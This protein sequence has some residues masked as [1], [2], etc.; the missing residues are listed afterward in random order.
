MARCLGAAR[1]VSQITTED[2]R[3]RI[4]ENEVIRVCHFLQPLK[5]T[6]GFRCPPR[7]PECGVHDVDRRRGGGGGAA[8]VWHLPPPPL[9]RSVALSVS[10]SV[11]PS[12]SFRPRMENNQKRKPPPPPPRQGRGRKKGGNCAVVGWINKQ[13]SVVTNQQSDRVNNSDREVP[14]NDCWC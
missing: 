1:Q 2:Q 12:V 7:K 10:V 3:P 8:V 11:G 14:K 9:S 5:I 6:K 13:Q 4:G